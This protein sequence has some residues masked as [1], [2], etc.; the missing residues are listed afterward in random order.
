MPASIYL[1]HVSKLFTMFLLY[2][3]LLAQLGLIFI[4]SPVLDTGCNRYSNAIVLPVEASRLRI[5]VEDPA[6]GVLTIGTEQVEKGQA[7]LTY[8]ATVSWIQHILFY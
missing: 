7:A 2:R 8:S 4:L 6:P 5:D 3:F 1:K